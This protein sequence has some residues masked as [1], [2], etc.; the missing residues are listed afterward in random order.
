MS[1]KDTASGLGIGLIVGAAIGLAV[2][3][4]YAPHAGEETRALIPVRIQHP[5]PFRAVFA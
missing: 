5:H 1:D 4:L 2:G 3:F